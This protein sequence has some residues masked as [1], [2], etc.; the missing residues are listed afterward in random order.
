[1]A[2]SPREILRRI[3]GITSTQQITKAMEMVAAVKLARVRM[4]AEKSRPYVDTMG[5]IMRA[6]CSSGED[7]QIPLF[8][9]RE[10]KKICLVVITSDRGLCGTF[11]AN[12]INAVKDFIDDN[13]GREVALVAVGRKG[14]DAFS[15]MGC[16]VYKKYDVPWGEAVE[17][18][19]REIAGYATEAFTSERADA[20]YLCYSR[21]ENVLKHV[22]T[23]VQYLPIPPLSAAEKKELVKWAVNFIIEPS[24]EEVATRLIPHYLE[25]QL[26]H[27]LIESLA[28]ECAARMV[29]MRNANDNAQEVIG[30]LTLSYNKARQA[31]I[32]KELIDIIGGV[33]ALRG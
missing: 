14:S 4:Q 18:A 32:T 28:S 31:T 24:F 8:V 33:E 15:K 29:S 27:C 26:Y 21:F 20:V 2:A 9:P 3:R 11:N 25:T 17:P 6:L 22:P 5:K 7:L 1:M 16:T 23:V 10:L 12:L 19:V 13:N 30:E